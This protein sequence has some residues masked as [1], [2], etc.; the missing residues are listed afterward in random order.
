MTNA[1]SD[2]RRWYADQD[3]PAHTYVTENGDS[4]S[5]P[6]WRKSHQKAKRGQ[7]KAPHPDMVH[8]AASERPPSHRPNPHRTSTAPAT[9]PHPINC[10]PQRPDTHRKELARP[11]PVDTRAPPHLPYYL[12]HLMDIPTRPPRTPSGFHTRGSNTSVSPNASILLKNP[13]HAPTVPLNAQCQL[14][15]GWGHSAVVC[16]SHD[17]KCY[18]C[19]KHEHLARACPLMPQ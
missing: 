19:S 1:H 9:V 15:L 4:Y 5:H 10:Q 3:F 16:K 2:H 13:S 18:S 11:I 14:C 17:S 7:R 8:H 6:F 12:P